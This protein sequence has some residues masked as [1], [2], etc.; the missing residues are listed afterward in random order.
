[1]IYVK[2]NHTVDIYNNMLE[3]EKVYSGFISPL[4]VDFIQQICQKRV[5]L[6]VGLISHSSA[7]AIPTTTAA[8]VTTARL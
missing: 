6:I 2:Q 7:A 5:N 1:M 4:N 8:A 3:V